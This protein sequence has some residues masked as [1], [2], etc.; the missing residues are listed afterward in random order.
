[1][2]QIFVENLREQYISSRFHPHDIQMRYG[3]KRFPSTFTYAVPKM[4]CISDI[5]SKTSLASSSLMQSFD[6]SI[7]NR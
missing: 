2:D 3:D 7:A 5:S 1:M 4:V 6:P